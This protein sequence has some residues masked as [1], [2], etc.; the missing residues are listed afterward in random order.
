[1]LGFAETPVG[2]RVAISVDIGTASDP[3]APRLPGELYGLQTD[4]SESARCEAVGSD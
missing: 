3:G 2:S 4:K 1:M